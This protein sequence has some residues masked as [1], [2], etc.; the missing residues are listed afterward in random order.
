M[1]PI[2]LVHSVEVQIIQLTVKK[3]G[4]KSAKLRLSNLVAGKQKG[5]LP[6]FAIVHVAGNNQPT[7]LNIHLSLRTR[8]KIVHERDV[9]YA[10]RRFRKRKRI[11]SDIERTS[12]LSAKPSVTLT[13]RTCLEF[14]G[15]E[16]ERLG[17]Y[18]E[19]ECL[20]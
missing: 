11:R 6:A 2:F 9:D 10:M 8:V 19:R 16:R 18:A 12:T 13:F 1:F 15:I 5:S 14:A 4:E 3:E 17:T 20:L 7:R